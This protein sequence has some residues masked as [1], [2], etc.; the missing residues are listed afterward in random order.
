MHGRTNLL[1]PEPVKPNLKIPGM[2]PN[3]DNRDHEDIDSLPGGIPVLVPLPKTIKVDPKLANNQTQCSKRTV[4]EQV[5]LI[6]AGKASEDNPYSIKYCS[7]FSSPANDPDGE[8][9]TIINWWKEN[10]AMYISV[11]YDDEKRAVFTEPEC[12]GEY[13]TITA[14]EVDVENIEELQGNMNI[15]TPEPVTPDLKI[16]GT[17][18]NPDNIDDKEKPCDDQEVDHIIE[19]HARV[20]TDA[21]GNK[22]IVV[23]VKYITC[24]V[25]EAQWDKQ[26]PQG[27]TSSVVESGD[28]ITL[29]CSK[30]TNGDNE[31]DEDD[32]EQSADCN[33]EEVKN[34][35]KEIQKAAVGDGKTIKYHVSMED[36]LVTVIEEWKKRNIKYAKEEKLKEPEFDKTGPDDDHIITIIVKIDKE[37]PPDSTEDSKEG[38]IC[39]DEDMKYDKKKNKCVVDELKKKQK[40]YEEAKANE[41]SKENRTL[42]ALSVAATGIGGMELAMGLSQ[43][44]AD[45]Y[46]DQSMA[47]YIATMRCTYGDGKQVKAGPD[48]I[49][50]PGGNSSELMSLRN[51]YFTLA[52]DLKERKDALGMK[53]GIESEEIID[54][55]QT[56]LYDDESLGIDSGAYASLYRAQMLGSEAD[57]SKIDDERK[58]SKN[59]VIAGGVLVGAGVIGGILG[60]SLINGKLGEKIKANKEKR[61]AKSSS[62][63]DRKEEI[64]LLSEEAKKRYAEKYG[65]SD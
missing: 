60:D 42:T 24:T 13:C 6:A 16:P 19:E 47:A 45:A 48:E 50:L 62:A 7:K 17:D 41:Q 25:D 18:P 15:L 59:R 55:A 8:V 23:D 38:C 27:Y 14:S 20:T 22:K 28:E 21:Q 4:A 49:E 61:K 52:K 34:K 57:Q 65:T 2:G 30:E 56:G 3:P 64:K 26:C 51:E 53:P 32:E 58:A 37:C 46:A 54:K 29:T 39:N 31:E 11:T 44:A 33:S 12:Q 36:C 1:T 10:I 43:Q 63:I 5:A 35:I 9:Q 40:E